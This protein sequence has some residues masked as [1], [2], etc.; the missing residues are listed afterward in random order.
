MSF[1]AAK[2]RKKVKSEERKVKN[3]A[4]NLRNSKEMS[5]FAPQ[6]SENIT[7]K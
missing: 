3:L 6:I 5:T 4:I 2:V 1:S 7:N